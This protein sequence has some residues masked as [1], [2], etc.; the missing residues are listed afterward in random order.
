MVSSIKEASTPIQASETSSSAPASTSSICSSANT[1]ILQST[2]IPMDAASRMPN[3]F[4]IR[5]I[6]LSSFHLIVFQNAEPCIFPFELCHFFII[7][8]PFCFVQYFPTFFAKIIHLLKFQDAVDP[9]RLDFRYFKI[10]GSAS[11]TQVNTD[12]FG[13]N[14]ILVCPYSSVSKSA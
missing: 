4:F 11:C 6:T 12:S 1:G 2:C 9:Y 5:C 10:R 13:V 8:H 7:A 14:R 3:V